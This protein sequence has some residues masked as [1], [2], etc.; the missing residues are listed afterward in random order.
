MT[1]RYA[2]AI[3]GSGPGGLGAA[4]RAAKLGVSHILLER[5]GHYSDT[6]FKYQKRKPVM[7]TPNR[8]P[9]R[10]DLLFDE[11]SREEVLGAWDNGMAEIPGI[12]AHLNAEV[13]TITGQ[14]G[15]F[16]LTLA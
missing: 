1:E 12:N 7:A 2:I 14:K 16:R 15:D 3:V 6:I 13:T 5:T 10:S 11:G 8:L 4:A 9:L